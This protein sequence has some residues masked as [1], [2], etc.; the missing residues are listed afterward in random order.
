MDK[1]KIAGMS[2]I[3]VDLEAGK[4]YAWC[5]CGESSNQPW[6]DGKHKSTSFTPVVF[7]AEES[8]TAFMCNCKYSGKPQF[9]DGTHTKL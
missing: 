7:K 8:K 4:T 9:C 2:P 1:P 6:C 5:S 3:A